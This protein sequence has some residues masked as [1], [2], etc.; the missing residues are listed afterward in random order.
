MIDSLERAEAAID[1][2]TIHIGA[3]NKKNTPLVKDITVPPNVP[4]ATW[5]ASGSYTA[6]RAERIV[7]TGIA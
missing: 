6:S 5:F 4:R 7:D 1:P 3:V 2:P